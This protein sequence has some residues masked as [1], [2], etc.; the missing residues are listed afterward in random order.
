MLLSAYD[1]DLQLQLVQSGVEARARVTVRNRGA[2]PLREL[3]LQISS[4]LHWESATLVA[5]ANRTALPLAQHRLQTDADHTGAATEA[6]LALP[7]PLAPG[8][9]V[10]LDLFYGGTLA[11]SSGRLQRLGASAAQGSS[12][13]W[14]GIGPEWTGL[15]GF[16]N[17]LWYPV[18]SP[19]LF[20]A[21]G[22]TL[23]EA[24]QQARAA[25]RASA[26]ALR[27]SVTYQGQAPSSVYFSTLR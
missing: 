3:P 25:E 5:G 6:V 21:D 22:N 10:M 20:L 8:A 26:I 11:Q 7:Q 23:F 2:E 17:V 19:Q 27:L 24:V 1:L 18:A 4:S 16:G 15:R 14:D 12:T 9:E 13:D